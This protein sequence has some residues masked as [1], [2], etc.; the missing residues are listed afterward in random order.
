[1][2][3]RLAL[4]WDSLGNPGDPGIVLVHSLG[5]DRSMWDSLSASLRGSHYVV[6]LD[7]RGH[8]VSPSPSGP[9][10]IEELA[11]DV[12]AVADAAGLSRFHVCGISLGGLVGLFLA[13]RHSA[14]LMSLVAANTAA[15]IGTETHWSE[16]IRAVRASGMDGIADAVIARWF[17]PGFRE[18][19]PATFA[20]LRRVFA[21]TQADGYV[22]CCQAIAAA[23]LTAELP[24]IAVPALIVGG[25][26]DPSTPVANARALHDGIP[27]SRLVVFPDAAHL[28]NLD[29]PAAFDRAVGDFLVSFDSRHVPHTRGRDPR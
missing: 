3:E 28:S 9:Y 24:H 4:S 1:M 6:R 13:A 22:A 12:L 10:S 25:E 7:L 8:G 26:L 29:V 2:S 21:T 17:A 19:E 18:R 23:D 11:D 16:R 15:K 14:R 27:G 20:H 5:A